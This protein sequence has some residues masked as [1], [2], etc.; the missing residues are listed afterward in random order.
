M[1]DQFIRKF[2][3]EYGFQISKDIYLMFY[4]NSEGTFLKIPQQDDEF[5]SFFDRN[6][7]SI[8]STKIIEKNLPVIVKKSN[9]F[10]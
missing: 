1:R 8:Y 6:T 2:V 9:E 4:E 7:L 10:I 5:N 3:M